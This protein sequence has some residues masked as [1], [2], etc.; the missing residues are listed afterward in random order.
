MVNLSGTVQ[1]LNSKWLGEERHQHVTIENKRLTVGSPE[2][3]FQIMP[4]AWH[5]LDSD[6]TAKDHPSQAGFACPS[7]KWSTNFIKVL[8]LQAK[9]LD[10]AEVLSLIHI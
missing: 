10:T 2:T 4:A 3:Q 1:P 6:L 5:S 9:T 7:T 8:A